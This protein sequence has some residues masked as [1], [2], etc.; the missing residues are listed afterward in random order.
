MSPDFPNDSILSSQ[1]CVEELKALP[2]KEEV[3]AK[4]LGG[5]AVRVM[6]L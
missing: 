5:N 1:R 2:L 3:K 4:R 6:G